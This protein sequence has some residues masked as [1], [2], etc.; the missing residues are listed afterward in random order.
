M[1]V[2]FIPSLSINV[3]FKFAVVVFIDD[4]SSFLI[5]VK[6][7]YAKEIPIIAVKA[8][9][10][11][12]SIILIFLPLTIYPMQNFYYLAFNVTYIIYYSNKKILTYVRINFYFNSLNS[13]S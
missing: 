4:V 6:L 9:I 5:T 3:N 10:T 7:K 13:Q 11:N 12:A 1:S 2:I 8:I